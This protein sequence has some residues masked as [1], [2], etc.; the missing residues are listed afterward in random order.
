MSG[1]FRDIALETVWEK[2][3]V[4]RTVPFALGGGLLLLATLLVGF[5]LGRFP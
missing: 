5:G 1:T 3:R 4:D 2:K